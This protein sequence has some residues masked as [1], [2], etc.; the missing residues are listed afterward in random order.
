MQTYNISHSKAKDVMDTT[1][2]LGV[3]L[4]SIKGVKH[5]AAGA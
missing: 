1:H 5:A 2:P 4:H 3:E